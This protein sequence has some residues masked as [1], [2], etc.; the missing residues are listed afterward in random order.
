M[1]RMKRM[2]VL[3]T[4]T[5]QCRCGQPF[6]IAQ[7]GNATETFALGMAQQA[8]KEGHLVALF[9][10]EEGTGSVVCCPVCSAE[11]QLPAS[12]LMSVP[13]PEPANLVPL[14]EVLNRLQRQPAVAP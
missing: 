7:K 2:K 12:E 8:Q 11:I 1:K 10:C 5:D 4:I 6:I 9:V 14:E 13:P 3:G